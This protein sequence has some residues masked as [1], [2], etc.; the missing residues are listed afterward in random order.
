MPPTPLPLPGGRYLSIE[1]ID[2]A[3]ANPSFCGCGVPFVFQARTLTDKG[4]TVDCSGYWC[5]ACDRAP[6]R[7]RK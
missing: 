7:P 3:A 4:Q 5:P 2:P 6:E 1:P